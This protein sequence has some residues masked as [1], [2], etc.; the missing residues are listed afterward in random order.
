MRADIERVD[1]DNRLQAEHNAHQRDLEAANRAQAGTGEDGAV[2]SPAAAY[3]HP[4]TFVY[5][6]PAYTS[7]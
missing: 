2:Q 7:Y 3:K 1:E 6:P 5:T 4:S